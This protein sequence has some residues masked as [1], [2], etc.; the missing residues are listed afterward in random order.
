MLEPHPTDPARV[1]RAAG[2]YAGRDFGDRL[3]QSFDRGTTW[4]EF[5]GEPEPPGDYSGLIFPVKLVGGQG[6]AAGRYYLIGRRDTRLGGGSS[7]FRT[8]DDGGSWSEV[9]SFRGATEP[10]PAD[11]PDV[12]IRGVA[13]DPAEPDRVAIGVNEYVGAGREARLSSSRIQLT[14]D[15]GAT[16][17]SL[18]QRELGAIYDLAL[19][20]DRKYEY[21]A[22][23]QGLFRLQLEP[24]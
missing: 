11:A 3:F 19:G 23:E 5:Y 4:S 21:A 8:D 1:F 14:T 10:R 18:G 16:W 13:F 2:C 7:L 9:L 12:L 24:D 15:G 6:A 17:N 20:I 22:T